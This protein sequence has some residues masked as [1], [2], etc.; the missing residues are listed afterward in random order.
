I[1]HPMKK[2]TLLVLLVSAV[3]YACQEEKKEKNPLEEANI[4]PV[5]IAAVNSLKLAGD[6]SASGLLTT[7]NEAKYA[8]KIGGVIS[9]VLVEE[10]QFFKKGQ[11]LA[12]LN[13]TEIAAGL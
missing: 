2:I 4:I 13:S 5:K 6:I 11:L 1:D 9:R 12:T 7:E 3:L 8:F 10:G